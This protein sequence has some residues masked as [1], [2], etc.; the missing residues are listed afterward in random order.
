[1]SH[2]LVNGTLTEAAILANADYLVT[3]FPY[4]YQGYPW[5]VAHD[6]IVTPYIER[7]TT[8]SGFD[9]AFG[10]LRFTWRIG[11]LNDE[12]WH[13]LA[14]TVFDG[15]LTAQLTVVTR[16]R[17]FDPD[18][19][20]QWVAINCKGRLADLTKEG[21]NPYEGTFYCPVQIEFFNGV[22]AAES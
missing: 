20:N 15:R 21:L 6:N 7:D 12:Q 9:G 22:Y 11:V 4:A 8:L 3:N 17:L 10:K 13:Y 2:R 1:M 5:L 16:N 19:A 18:P 14:G